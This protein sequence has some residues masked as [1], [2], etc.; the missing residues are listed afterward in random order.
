MA[1]LAIYRQG[2]VHRLQGRF[3]RAEQAYRDARAGGY[4]PQPGLA[5]LRY[6]PGDLLR[7]NQ[8]IK[9]RA[10]SDVGAIA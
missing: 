4:E 7:L 2:E 5:L 10:A 3:A 9:P 8:N 1:A 6:D